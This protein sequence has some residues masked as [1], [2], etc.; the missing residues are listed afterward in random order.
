[1]FNDMS[2]NIV[3]FAS[4]L[5]RMEPPVLQSTT[6]EST[7]HGIMLYFEDVM[8]CFGKPFNRLFHKRDWNVFIPFRD[9]QTAFFHCY[10][11]LA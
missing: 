7:L 5:L 8:R 9:K 11:F 1:M 10:A 3:L 4:I 2:N 6:F